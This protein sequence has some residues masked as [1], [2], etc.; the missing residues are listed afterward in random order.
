[1]GM[2][3]L[4]FELHPAIFR[5]CVFSDDAQMTLLPYFANS[6]GF[7]FEK[8][9]QTSSSPSYSSLWSGVCEEKGEDRLFWRNVILDT[10]SLD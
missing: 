10:K 1:M 3:G 8:K 7:N 5:K 9:M 6:Y 2:A 4:I